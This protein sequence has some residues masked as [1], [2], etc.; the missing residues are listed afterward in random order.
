MA[1]RP[2]R[3]E[4]DAR[5]MAR[6]VALARRGLGRTSPNP[7]VGA[8]V[9]RGGR[10]VGEGWHRRAGGPHAEVVALR[11]AGT[12]ARGATLYVTL[13]PCSH[14]GRTPPCADAV[15]AAG[16]ARVVAAV[17]DPNP[18]V[19]GR[20]LRKLR[21]ARIRT[22]TGVL[23]DEAGEVSAWWR[24]FVVQRRPYVLLKLAAT[25]DGRIAT[26]RGE[27]RWVS[28]APARRFVHALRDRVDAVMV[29]AGTVLA[30]DP[31]LTCR[32]RGGRDPLRVVVD[33]RLRIGPR[34]R[35]VRQRSVAATL[36]A[37]TEAASARR[38]RAL[39]AA[40]AEV[41]LFP[42]RG[43]RMRIGALLA[44]LG[45]R[46]VV[47]VLVEGGGDLAAAMLRERVVDRLLLVSA[48]RLLGGDARPM[49]GALGIARLARTPRLV[50]SRVV[51]LG[52]D[53]LWEGAVQY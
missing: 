16:V 47:S 37:T 6:A 19:R 23:A 32:V 36:V 49:L 12:A 33:G 52:S 7:P 50:E 35:V 9:V 44:V 39:V 18:R 31:A 51:R 24:H 13:E 1:R 29:G 5:F 21:A 22:E 27:S 3:D 15:I 43:G 53:L 40:G 28:G 20:G 14:H 2:P 38:R 17:G 46:G 4:D 30:D 25:L 10:I 26:A 8:V 45:A 34:A 42:G 41:L 11:Q 48:P